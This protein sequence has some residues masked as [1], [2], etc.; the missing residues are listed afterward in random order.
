MPHHT[1]K[2]Q[3]APIDPN[4]GFSSIED[5]A[6]TDSEEERPLSLELGV[7]AMR[8]REPSWKSAKGSKRELVQPRPLRPEDGWRSLGGLEKRFAALLLELLA[9]SDRLS[10]DFGDQRFHTRPRGLV[11]Q[12]GRNED[13]VLKC[14]NIPSDIDSI[15]KMRPKP[16]FGD[17]WSTARGP[18][19]PPSPK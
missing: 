6:L 4:G 8:L 13:K 11:H 15:H 12:Y 18:R 3:F 1:P 5:L 9:S 19:H 7:T 17:I 10:L 2:R 14:T 16:S